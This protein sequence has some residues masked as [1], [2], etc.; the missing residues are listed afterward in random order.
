MN[1]L[2]LQS[3]DDY[4]ELIGILSESIIELKNKEEIFLKGKNAFLN[5]LEDVNEAFQELESLFLGLVRSMVS[6]LDA[7]SPWTKG[8]SER[9]A[10]YAKKIAETMELDGD[11]I[12][13]LQLAVLLHDIGKIGTYDYLLDKPERLTNDEYE[14]VKKHPAQGAKILESIKQ[15]QD[16]IPFVKYH[17]ERFDGK[18]YPEGLMGNE[19]PFGARILHVADSFDSMSKDRPYRPAPGVDYAISEFKKYSGTQFD[20]EVVK[21]LFSVLEKDGD[22]L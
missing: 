1:E 15:L 19:I 8:H 12:K 5:M 22:E 4:Q 2:I 14:I 18:G 11:E 20:S 3:D 10:L 16:V 7:K 21:A 17:H 13:N 9:V 6:A